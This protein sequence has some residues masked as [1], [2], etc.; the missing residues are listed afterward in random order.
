MRCSCLRSGGHRRLI[1]SYLSTDGRRGPLQQISHPP[2][3]QAL[4]EADLNH[5]AFFDAE[6]R[7]G[8]GYNTLPK[9]SGVAL[10]ICGQAPT[11]RQCLP[12]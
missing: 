12:Q 5:G 8:N 7:I 3:A 2:E 1:T 11:F 9:W 6:F 4:L 10:R